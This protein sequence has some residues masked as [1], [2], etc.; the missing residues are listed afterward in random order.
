MRRHFAG[1]VVIEVTH[2]RPGGER[3]GDCRRIARERNVKHGDFITGRGLDACN[4]R[5]VAL[6]AG[7]QFGSTR[8][9]QPQL[10]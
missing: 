10:V 5:N 6:D 9:L 2:F 4:Q 3:R 8:R 7:D 1:I